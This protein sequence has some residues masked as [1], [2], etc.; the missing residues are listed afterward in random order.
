MKCPFITAYYF[1]IYTLKLLFDMCIL[2]LTICF[3]CSDVCRVMVS[4]LIYLKLH[5][6]SQVLNCVWGYTFF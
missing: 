5:A 2:P 6:F 4:K 3:Q 1:S